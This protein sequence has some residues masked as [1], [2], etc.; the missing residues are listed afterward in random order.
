M[1]MAW[2]RGGR[3]TGLLRLKW[4]RVISILSLNLLCPIFSSPVVS[5]P[6]PS[7]AFYKA[8]WCSHFS[9]LTISKA[10]GF[11]SLASD[12]SGSSSKKLPRKWASSSPFCALPCLR[13]LSSVLCSQV[14]G[15]QGWRRGR[16]RRVFKMNHKQY[17]RWWSAQHG[18]IIG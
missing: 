2:G 17:W 4:I 12:S 14:L 11:Y 5:P 10:T 7:K 8:D 16:Q 3:W 13:F 18:Y 15:P 6:L 1:S 9:P